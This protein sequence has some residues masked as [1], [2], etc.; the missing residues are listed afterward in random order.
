M[1]KRQEI[2][3]TINNE[4]EIRATLQWVK[5]MSVKGLPRGPV[6]VRLGRLRRTL[7]QNRKLWP[8]LEDVRKQVDW[9]G[10][11]L[12]CEDW[13]NIF[14]ASLRG[15]RAVP[16]IDG[17]VVV[18]GKSTS[19]M[20]KSEFSELVELIYAFGSQRAVIWSEKA[21]ANYHAYGRAANDGSYESEEGRESGEAG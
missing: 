21:Q 13:K 6:V 4:T 20:D 15:Q 1:S 11:E 2:E 8:M 19:R 17:G 3:K 16:G 12:A 7:D 10:F 5:D 9:Y 18:L 14:T